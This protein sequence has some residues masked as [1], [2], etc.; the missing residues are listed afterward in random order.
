[1]YG[2]IQQGQAQKAAA[3]YQTKVM[4][5]NAIIANQN[6]TLTLQ[7]GQAQVEAQQMKTASLIGS[8]RAAMA[9]NGVQLNTGSP[10]D[11]QS[12]AATLGELNALTIRSNAQNT[13]NAYL[14]TASTDTSQASAYTALGQNQSSASSTAAFSSALSTAS[15]VGDKWALATKNG[16]YNGLNLLN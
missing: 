1:L 3:D 13:A 8:Q 9:A 14:N 2:N 7:Q 10:L 5:N 4:Q 12:S 11:V 16:T 15:S 6:A